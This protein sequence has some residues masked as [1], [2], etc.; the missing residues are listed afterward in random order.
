VHLFGGDVIEK[1]VAIIKLRVHNRGGNGGGCLEINHGTYTAEI[2]DV[3]KASARQIS[4]VVSERQIF[5]ENDTKVT[6][7]SC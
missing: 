3:H 4:N 1:C 5:I 7:R 2:P 6:D